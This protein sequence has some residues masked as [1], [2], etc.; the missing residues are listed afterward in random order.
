[1]NRPPLD[2]RVHSAQGDA[3]QAEGRL[4]TSLGGGA[5][6]RPGI[7]LMASGLPHARWN[8]GDVTDASAVDWRQVRAWYAAQ[9][10]GAGVPWGVR[11][12]ADAP[13]GQGR[14]VLRQRCMAL[15]PADRRPATT[16]ERISL[17]VASRADLD[18]VTRI[19]AEA[20]EVPADEVRPWI[21]P[22]LG[23]DR[24][25]VAI[26]ELDGAPVGVAT[27]L[28]TNDRAG[29]A[30]GIFG[31]GVVAAARRRGVATA[32]TDWLLACGFAGGATLAHLNP[33]SE[34][35]ARLYRRL[36][37]VEVRGFDVYTDL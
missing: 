34:A 8:N 12:A 15:L 3:W 19:D 26:A 9:A 35:A 37:F 27:A 17:R 10:N 23:A 32:L 31:V 6:E 28:N 5:I 20:F 22:R 11:V 18:A 14:R 16:T 2:A 25:T 13:F 36:G 30:I 4:R 21:A 33:D 24:C 29:P 1:V 7:R